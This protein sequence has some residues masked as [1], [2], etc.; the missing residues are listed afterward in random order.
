MKT[1]KLKESDI[2]RI[3]NRTL[4]EQ[5]NDED[6]YHEEM[7]EYAEELLDERSDYIMDHLSYCLSN[8]DLTGI[9]RDTQDRFRAKYDEDWSDKD[10]YWD[11]AVDI[12]NGSI[13]KDGFN[14]KDIIYSALESIEDRVEFQSKYDGNTSDLTDFN[15]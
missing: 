3:I 6:K 14:N 9:Y 10:L 15:K 1:I 12:V 11:L 5:D 13:P 4:K 7:T 2:Q 8:L